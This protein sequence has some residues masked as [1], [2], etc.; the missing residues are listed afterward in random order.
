MHI[1][2]SLEP[3]LPDGD[4]ERILR[5]ALATERLGFHSVLMSGHVLASTGSAVDP[6]VA[7][8]AV[9][10]ATTRVRLM[11][12]VLVLPYYEPIVLANQAATL[13]VLSGGRFTMALGVGWKASE[14][15]ALSVPF[16]QRGARTDEHL[17]AMQTLWRD[18]PASFEGRF[19]SFKDATLGVAPLTP[20]GPPIWIGGD[21]DA[22]LRRTVRYGQ[23]WFGTAPTPDAFRDLRARLSRIAE[24]EQRDI[25]ALELNALY[26]ITPP[27][28]EAP[29]LMLGNPLG[30]KTPSGPSVIEDLGALRQAGVSKVMLYLPLNADQVS[31]G[32]EWV[33]AEVLSQL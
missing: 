4:P 19:T 8:A 10:G 30:G 7:L 22:A 27:G 21:S 2:I 17:Q 24:Q 5:V 20:G 13:D 28:F 3:V 23:A 31:D 14:F 32:L 26:F 9:A 12:G 15:E 29:G 1:G 16:T 6:M 11:T 18:R 25:S 33:A